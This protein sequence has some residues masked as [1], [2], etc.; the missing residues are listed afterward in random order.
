MRPAHAVAPV[1]RLQPLS[2]ATCNLHHLIAPR[3]LLFATLNIDGD[4]APNLVGHH[5]DGEMEA[6][7]GSQATA[8][9]AGNTPTF[10]ATRLE[11]PFES[12]L[13]WPV[14]VRLDHEPKVGVDPHLKRPIV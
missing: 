11:L 13:R 2:A 6:V 5:R 7:L 12:P 9:T 1:L 10:H 14:T 4:G 8:P 3:L